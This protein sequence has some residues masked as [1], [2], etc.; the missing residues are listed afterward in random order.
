M[1]VNN[2]I[3][4]MHSS[5]SKETE[6]QFPREK[7]ENHPG[8]KLVDRDEETGLEQFCYVKCHNG[9][10]DFLKRCR[11]LVYSGER[12]ILKSFPYTV[13]YTDK[14]IEKLQN[15]F[16]NMKTWSFFPSFEGALIRVFYFEGKWF[17]STHRKLDAF[18]SKWSSSKSFGEIFVDSI[19]SERN[20]NLKFK[21]KLEQ[22]D[23]NIL[24]NFYNSLDKRYKYMF[25]LLNTSENR[26]VCKPPQDCQNKIFHVG[27]FLEDDTFSFNVDC[28]LPSPKRLEFTELQSLLKFVSEVN[29]SQSQGVIAFSDSGE[30]IKIVNS[31]YMELFRVRGNEPSVKFRYLQVRRDNNMRTSL[32]QLYPEHVK[33]FDNY[34][35]IIHKIAV[36]I[37]NAYVDRF[38]R[39]EY[40][41]VG[42]EEYA[43]VSECHS[44]YLSDRQHNKISLEKVK[45]VL[46]RQ[47]PV[48]LNTMIRR[49]N[50][51]D[52]N[53][54]IRQF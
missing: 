38:I 26:I 52:T 32:Y 27:T 3:E 39:K 36:G 40:V 49:Y 14:D 22:S 12:L 5:E 24:N 34:E 16:T 35:N 44:W 43:V 46:D 18:R 37:Y 23:S 9:D 1:S 51:E 4:I 47:N 8:I 50:T 21:E 13:E 41:V 29:I 2:R 6:I 10:S 48:N 30:Q 11:G 31:S 20:F 28:G 7:I 19:D 42:K 54:H 17:L 33:T 15:I 53:T 45:E 25:L